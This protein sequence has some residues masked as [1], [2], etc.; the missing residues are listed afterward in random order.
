M[1]FRRIS[2]HKAQH[3]FQWS[4]A[5]VA[6]C[7]L[8]T[9]AC[10]GVTQETTQGGSGGGNGGNGG[11]GGGGSSGVDCSLP[12]EP[13]PA[14]ANYCARLPGGPKGAFA[15]PVNWSLAHA[16]VRFFGVAP[17]YDV[18]D[19]ALAGALGGDDAWTGKDLSSY[20]D[21]L[22]GAA[23][24][25]PVEE[26]ALGAASVTMEGEVAILRPG[27]GNIE[28]PEG[29]KGVL[30]DL[31]DVP[32]ANGAREA[33]WA[34]VSVALAAPHDGLSERVR[35]HNGMVD[36]MF[37]EMN[38]YGNTVAKSDLPVVPAEGTVDLPL[39][40]LTGPAMMPDAVEIALTL[41]LAQRAFVVGED[42]RTEVAEARWQGVGE[43]GVAYR[44]R[45]LYFGTAR[46][47]DVV[48]ADKRTTAPECFAQD[49]LSMG[50]VPQAGT[51]P[52]E[53]SKVLVTKPFGVQQL[54]GDPLGDARAALVISHGAA[55]AF[56]PYFPTV[57]DIIDERLVETAQALP[58]VPTR[59]DEMN[60]LRRFGEALS[61]GHQFVA[62]YESDTVGFL[63]VF[64]EDIGGKAVIR[65]SNEPSIAPGDTI[66]EIDG[67]PADDWYALELS[68]SG[69]ASPGYKHDIATRQLLYMKGPVT[70]GL[71][72]ID[73]TPK[74]VTV[75]PHPVDD[76]LSI[77]VASSRPAGD[78]ADMGAPDLYY[79]NMA[80]S[81]LDDMSVFKSAL[82]AAS[83]AKGLVIDMRGYPG[84]NHYEVA[85]RLIQE[86]F[87]SPIFHVRQYEGPKEGAIDEASFPLGSLSNPSFSG[88]V[89]LLVSHHT[90]SAAENFSIMLVDTQ[91]VTVIGQQSAATNGNI[92]GVQLP[93]HFGFSFTGMEVLH[94]DAAKS[95]FHGIGIVPDIE[96]PLLAQDFADGTDAELLAAIDWLSMQ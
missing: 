10:G 82:T 67:V 33:I 74:T 94:A 2:E 30:V 85:Q 70:L 44:Y 90:V 34:A 35:K 3:A 95:V 64:I 16:G 39:A 49:L 77:I 48:Y 78:L 28:L 80:S 31:R 66:T 19:Q 52:N 8:L 60:A 92:T 26:K 40:L 51:G 4:F 86:T 5:L 20:S 73:G 62:S 87:S 96:V 27:T 46:V 23:C 21:A 1:T 53:R 59:D 22:L 56:Y 29:T 17:S 69:G 63:P 88:P 18:A 76:L 55:R 75:S 38:V 25:L 61:D 24:A 11:N 54:P 42:L 13:P 68:R 14:S 32:W 93:G 65:R 81:V 83:S 36:E 58:D 71:Q 15:T 84:I 6:L 43:M 7:A 50:A 91:R 79:I 47:A 57:G 12:N 72:S 89:A 45:E 41:R 37:S 9:T